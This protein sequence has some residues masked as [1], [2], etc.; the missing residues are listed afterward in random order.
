MAT[1]RVVTSEE[2]QRF[3][4]QLA[5]MLLFGPPSGA[6]A[7]IEAAFG[8]PVFADFAART[9]GFGGT[10]NWLATEDAKAFGDA[11]R[12]KD[13]TALVGFIRRGLLKDGVSARDARA[14][15]AFPEKISSFLGSE[16]PRRL[17]KDFPVK[18]GR[19]ANVQQRDY[20]E[21]A[22]MGERL[23][24]VC[25]L[26][27]REQARKTKRTVP[28]ILDFLAI[29]YPEEVS[30]LLKHLPRFEAVLKNKNLAKRATKTESRARIMADA[31]AGADFNLRPRTSLERARTGRR[32]LKRNPT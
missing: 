5:D 18:L 27:V 19:K 1:E 9:M 16:L 6:K 17:K 7:L 10:A 8:F 23:A 13:R 28:Q 15:L 31:M 26:V 32:M 24:P 12:D 29:D 25:E 20:P 22:K 4:E 21:I 30:F 3:A 11:V 14:L 2:A